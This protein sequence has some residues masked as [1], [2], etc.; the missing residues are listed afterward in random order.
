MPQHILQ[1]MFQSW[2]LTCDM[3]YFLLAPL[4]I[5]PLWRWPKPGKALLALITILSVFVPFAVTLLG[6]LDAVLLLF[7]R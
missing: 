7:M 6:G 5:Y 1:C 2:F 3:H 4:V